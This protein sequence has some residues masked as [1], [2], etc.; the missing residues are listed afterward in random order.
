MT[1]LS[2]VQD[3]G[4]SDGPRPVNL[5]TDLAPLA[6]LIEL[7]FADSMDQGGR[8]AVREMRTL[9][10]VGVG[11]SLLPGLS[12]LTQGIN[13][14]YVWIADG[15][16]VGNVSTYPTSKPYRNTWIIA[17]VGVHPDYQQR[18]IAT[19][20][21]RASMETIRARGGVRAILQVDASN[22]V[23]RRL[24]E[25]LG[26]VVE[27]TWTTWRRSHSIRVPA[28]LTDQAV[29]VSYRRP[30]EWRA[31]Y[32]LAQ[33]VRP[34]ERGGMGWQRP[35]HPDLFR[36]SLLMRIGDWF[37]MRTEERLVIRSED[38]ARILASL[39]IE[40]GFLT[41]S[42]HLTL[43]TAPEYQGLYD[44][45]LIGTAVRRFSHRNSALVLEHP[46]DETRTSEVLR[47]YQFRPQRE[48]VHMR[49]DVR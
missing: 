44:E 16:L 47:E 36:K 13:L 14:G 28:P 4:I 23:A 35:L 10:R 26:F 25:R 3:D 7:V 12:D 42:T 15:K 5:R 32:A 9:S 21:M 49:W 38:E 17:N 24:Y 46:T 41:A 37:N 8:A 30:G 33:Q 2:S 43:M 45:V 20:L 39:W 6:D 34:E 31:E 11:I 18:G 19:Q 22:S 48:V 27:R 40:G 1:S 29:H